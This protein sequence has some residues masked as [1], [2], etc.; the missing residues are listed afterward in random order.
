MQSSHRR[1][2][3][4]PPS[5]AI[6]ELRRFRFLFISGNYSRILSS[7]GRENDNFEVCRASTAHQSFTILQSASHTVILL[8]HDP[9]IFEGAEEMLF[10]ISGMLKDSGHES[11]VMLYS[12]SMDRS[13]NNLMQKADR[14]I[15]IA[16]DDEGAGRQHQGSTSPRW[17]QGSHLPQ[18]RTLEVT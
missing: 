10:K 1:R 14:I 8:E 11:L 17:I 6:R 12:P 2:C 3:S 7:L 4:S 13:F 18:Q 16:F 5:I 15:E 9:T